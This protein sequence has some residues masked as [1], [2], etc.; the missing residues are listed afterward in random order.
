MLDGMTAE[1]PKR[2]PAGAA[3]PGA[4]DRPVRYPNTLV[5]LVSDET[6]AALELERKRSGL[7]KGEVARGWLEAGRRAAG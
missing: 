4:V 3:V 1:K 2:K 6:K 5:F 7:S